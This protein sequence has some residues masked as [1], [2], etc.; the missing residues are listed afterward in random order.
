MT[1]SLLESIAAELRAYTQTSS[2][3]VMETP[4]GAAIRLPPA[5]GADYRFVF[6]RER[7]GEHCISVELV[8]GA[9]GPVDS[10]LWYLHQP[11]D[12]QEFGECAAQLAAAFRSAVQELVHVRTRIRQ[13]RG[14][15]V[16]KVY[17]EREA[18][19]DS[20]APVYSCAFMRWR[21][22]APAGGAPR[23]YHALP[24]APGRPYPPGA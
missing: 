13:E 19:P 15:L 23:T 21:G 6:S 22:I 14:W 9:A 10:H 2:I 8:D 17:L 1:D 18:A 5:D 24:V 12:L 7:T 4:W 11:F 16:W 20:W 3:V